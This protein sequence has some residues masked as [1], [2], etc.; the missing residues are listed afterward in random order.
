MYSERE[1][2][3]VYTNAP[4]APTRVM[5]QQIF[6]AILTDPR[7]TLVQACTEITMP[8]VRR[9]RTPITYG[10]SSETCFLQRGHGANPSRPSHTTRAPGLMAPISLSLEFTQVH[11]DDDDDTSLLAS[12]V[13]RLRRHSPPTSLV[14]D[15]PRLRR[16]SSSTSLVFDVP[17]LRRHSLRR[18]PRPSCKPPRWHA[19]ATATMD[20]HSHAGHTSG[21]G[22]DTNYAFA[23]D[24][25]YLVAAVVG[26][27]VLIRAV[28]HVGARQRQAARPPPSPRALLT[29][30][31]SKAC[32]GPH[33][34]RATRPDGRAGQAW[35]TATALVRELG[36]PQLYV[37][38]KGLRWA[39][40]PPLGRVLVLLAYW[41]VIVYFMSWRVVVDDAFYWERIGYRVA[42]VTLTQLPLLFLL[43]MKVNP[44]G[45]LIGSSHERLNWLHRWVARTMLVTAT[46][47]GFHFWTEWVRADFVEYQLS[48]MP[49]V[50]Y[51]LGAWGLLLWSVVVGFLPVRRLAYELW[52]AQH[53]VTSVVLLY[54][55]YR[56]IP[57]NA[58][59]LLWMSIAFL[60]FDRAARWLLLLWRN[61]AWTT[62]GSS[63]CDARRRVGHTI[64]LRTMGDATTVVTVKDVHFPWRAGQHV[65]LWV[66]RLGPLEA[67]PYTIACAHR[68][69]GTCCC[70]SIQLI[71]RE[72]KGFS[73]RLR[74]RAARHPDRTLTAFVSGPFGAPPRWDAYETL[75]LIGASTGASFAIPVLEC[76][77]AATERTCV[78]RIEVVL[79]ARTADEIAYFVD[80][81]KEAALEARAKG[82]D[83]RLH[84]AITGVAGHGECSAAVPLVRPWRAGGGR[85]GTTARRESNAGCD[86]HPSTPTAESSGGCC[87]R[88]RRSRR[89]SAAESLDGRPSLECLREYTARPDI[90]ALIREP[91]EQAWGETAVAVCGGKELVARTRNCVAKLSDE[92]AVH[93]GTGA[94]GIYLH[95]EEYAF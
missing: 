3:R 87:C 19:L 78:R 49:I 13:T 64:S 65:Y 32:R 8:P 33:P 43:A 16:P 72:H 18:H 47:H 20:T 7:S 62:R 17:R 36:H 2:A 73:R 83:V 44:V 82:V 30:P 14:F 45:W 54:L 63:A 27:L 31:R 46:V 53:V 79:I 77:A 70:S 84:V 40:P 28:N 71:V 89:S 90:E 60:V 81:A 74:E 1:A 92:R 42:W 12:D 61:T 6:A 50:R 86:G 94:Q 88:G 51:G 9:R 80:R 68:V 34:E 37:P 35:A 55:L 85:R 26:L 57:A 15:V 69:E 56:H 25:W 66:P 41:A 23:D 38:I 91:V 4:K 58:R 75:V 24:F 39:T 93:K 10:T 5:S 67:H 95:V 29:C 21:M 11:D 76:A 59:Y 48:A 22:M 52:L